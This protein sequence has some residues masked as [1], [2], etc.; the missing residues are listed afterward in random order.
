[1]KLVLGEIDELQASLVK[2]ISILERIHDRLMEHLMGFLLKGKPLMVRPELGSDVFFNAVFH[3]MV[4]PVL[5][6]DRSRM[7]MRMGG[8][9]VGKEI[10]VWIQ[11]LLDSLA[12]SLVQR[13]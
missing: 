9:K 3:T 10:K 6:S 1:M 13:A 12:A 4:H 8:T 7:A 5:A 2:D 11:A